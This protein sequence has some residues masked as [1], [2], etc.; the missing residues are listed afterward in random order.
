MVGIDAEKF[1]LLKSK[2]YFTTKNL[3]PLQNKNLDI[4]K[5][6]N[7]KKISAS[8]LIRWCWTYIGVKLGHR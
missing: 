8:V 2:K 3:S 7:R 4:V 1:E 6:K 5:K